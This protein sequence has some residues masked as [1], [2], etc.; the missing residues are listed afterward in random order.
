M[1]MHV[2]R[3]CRGGAIGHA[4]WLSVAQ[5]PPFSVAPHAPLPRD[6]LSGTA[7][8]A[9][10]A[11]CAQERLSWRSSQIVPNCTR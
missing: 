4:P 11:A 3:E 7:L 5:S 2:A 1:A 9:W 6:T 10:R 8:G